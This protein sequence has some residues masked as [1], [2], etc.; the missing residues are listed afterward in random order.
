[1][2]LRR[3]GA[4]ACPMREDGSLDVEL[5]GLPG[6]DVHVYPSSERPGW[7]IVKVEYAGPDRDTGEKGFYNVRDYWRRR[8]TK[9]PSAEKVA[10]WAKR[11]ILRMMSHELDE[12][13]HVGGKRI[14][15]PHK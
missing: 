11:S 6:W 12:A 15:D 4:P 8:G 7:L 5:R 14:L 3:R 13:M 9:P 2:N 1:M 10:G